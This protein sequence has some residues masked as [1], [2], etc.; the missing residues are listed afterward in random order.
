MGVVKANAYGHGAVPVAEAMLE[1]GAEY[2]AVAC[3]AEAEELRAAGISAPIL[4]L[5][6]TPTLFA[7]ALEELGL[8]H[9]ARVARGEAEPAHTRV[10]LEMHPQLAVQTL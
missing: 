5:G 1:A 8:P 6:V 10:E 3:L 7:G 9:P 2:L 4:V